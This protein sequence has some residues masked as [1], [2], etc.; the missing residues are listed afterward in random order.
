MLVKGTSGDSHRS[1]SI[2][3]ANTDLSQATIAQYSRRFR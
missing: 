1:K 3:D 2:M